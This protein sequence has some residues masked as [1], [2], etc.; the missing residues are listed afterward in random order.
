MENLFEDLPPKEDNLFEDLVPEEDAPNPI[1]DTSISLSEVAADNL[2][3]IGDPREAITAI[4]GTILGTSA[5]GLAGIGTAAYEGIK[6]IPGVPGDPDWD[7]PAGV[8]RGIQESASELFEPSTPGGKKATEAVISGIETVGKAIKTPIA[9]G[10]FPPGG[11]YGE[12]R[13]RMINEPIGEFFG[14][15]MM[16]RGASPEAATAARMAPDVALASLGIRKP[17]TSGV[18]FRDIDVPS[19][20]VGPTRAQLRDVRTP[21]PTRTI[22]DTNVPVA[23]ATTTTTPQELSVAAKTVNKRKQ[24]ERMLKLIDPNPEIALAFKELD[25]TP[26]P[27]MVSENVAIR[28]TESALKSAPGSPL[29]GTTA[30]V[31]A[32][33]QDRAEALVRRFGDEDRTVI[34]RNLRQEFDEVRTGLESQAKTAFTEMNTAERLATRTRPEDL[35]PLTRYLDEQVDAMGSVAELSRMDKR[36]HNM[37]YR[38]K[39]DKAGVAI[40]GEYVLKPITYGKLN[41]EREAIG[42]AL[43]NESIFKDSTKAS[44]D[45]AYGILRASQ[46]RSASR[47]GFGDDYVAANKL[48]I[49]RKALELQSVVAL[50]RELERGIIGFIDQ[51]ASKVPKG[52]INQFRRVMNAIPE[53]YRQPVVMAIV[54]RIMLRG[55][56]RQIKPSF[57]NTVLDLEKN[58]LA[59]D[60]LFSYLPPRARIQ[61]ER[62]AKA[63]KGFFRSLETDNPSGTAASLAI[64]KSVDD[65]SMAGKLTGAGG[66]IFGA[67][68]MSGILGLPPGAGTAAVVARRTAAAI[69][70]RTGSPKM[71][72]SERGALFMASEDL[73]RAVVD[74]AAGRAQQAQKILDNSAIYKQWLTTVDK[75]EAEHIARV[76]FFAWM[77]EKGEQQ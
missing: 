67:E 38:Q 70:E 63:S 23:K 52:D 36:L 41:A 39:T 66:E 27:G 57:M 55:E 11:P 2:K 74:Y 42:N 5:A 34:D 30:E 35:Q 37:I 12:L 46:G 77:L 56:G 61:F 26:T 21:A 31:R 18:K 76:G 65:G 47:L 58:A 8:V 53:E 51:A 73:G 72:R 54:E 49:D 1:A 68:W 33:L 13:E 59:K 17:A 22:A 19:A 29:K 16:E 7:A 75:V 43:K 20:P 28:Q 45:H 6:A 4:T 14:D 10:A 71:T 32:K 50:G 44:I 15:R 25:I 62:I 69:K 40:K 24:N 48:I 9:Y 64:L 3:W 60:F